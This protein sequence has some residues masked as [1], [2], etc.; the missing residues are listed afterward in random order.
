MTFAENP[1]IVESVN[2]T[3]VSESR[4]VDHPE[5]SPVEYAEDGSVISGHHRE[6]ARRQVHQGW[7]E[8]ISIPRFGSDENDID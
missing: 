7:R 1:V 2:G 8:E 3:V 6:A 5:I 4:Q